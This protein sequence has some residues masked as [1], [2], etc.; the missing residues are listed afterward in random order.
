MVLVNI[1]E[2]FLVTYVVKMI[3]YLEPLVNFDVYVVGIYKLV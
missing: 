2:A 3:R 1:F